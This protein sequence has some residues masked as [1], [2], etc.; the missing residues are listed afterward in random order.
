M[1]VTEGH[2]TV[3]DKKAVNAIMQAGLS[4]GKV[5]SVSYFITCDAGVYTV[6]KQVKD[7]GLVPVPGTPLRWSRYTSKF[8]KR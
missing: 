4:E 2:L 1:K 5:G 8:T 3:K 6:V 7:R